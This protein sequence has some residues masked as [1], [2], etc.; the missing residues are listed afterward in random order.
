VPGNVHREVFLTKMDAVRSD[1]QANVYVV[2][3][4]QRRPR[5]AADPGN[6]L[7]FGEF[8]PDRPLLLTKLDRVGSAADRQLREPVRPESLLVV[9]VCK[10]VKSSYAMCSGL[11]HEVGLFPRMLRNL[12]RQDIFLFPDTQASHV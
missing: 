10:D 3:N 5:L 9:I 7:R 11:N 8:V 4:N 1:P 12:C 6:P 2:I